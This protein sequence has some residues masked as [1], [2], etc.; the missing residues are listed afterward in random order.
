MF[1]EGDAGDVKNV[2]LEP[3]FVLPDQAVTGSRDIRSASSK[4]AV[5]ISDP[6]VGYV[7]TNLAK[8]APAIEKDR[9][10]SDRLV[11][12]RSRQWNQCSKAAGQADRSICQVFG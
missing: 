12:T 11:T 3:L 8:W 6:A 7:A 4:A 5:D 2:A 9:L 10:Q 1:S